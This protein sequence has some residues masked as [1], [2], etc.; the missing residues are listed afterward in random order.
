MMY[1]PFFKRINS[2]GSLFSSYFCCDALTVV[3]M[4]VVKLIT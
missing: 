1:S 2:C 4:K 3:T